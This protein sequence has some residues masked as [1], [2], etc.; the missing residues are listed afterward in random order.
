MGVDG[1]GLFSDDTA[2]DVRDA[3]REALEDGATDAAAEASVL[4]AFSDS[5]ADDDEGVVVWLAL[6]YS[7]SKLGRL[8]DMTRQRALAVL[9]AGADLA[10]WS[11]TGPRGV[12][13]R[14]AALEKVRAQLTGP[15]PKRRKVR[16]PARAVTGLPVGQV[17]G[18][19]ARSGRLYLMRV[20][21]LFDTRD[22]LYPVL[23]FLDYAEPDTPASAELDDIDDLAIGAWLIPPV[24]L[25]IMDR[26]QGHGLAVIGSLTIAR[27]GQQLANW[28]ACDWSDLTQHLDQRDRD[29]YGAQH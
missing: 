9:D 6:A 25:V 5:L 13:Q 1:P 7:Q 17:L 10:R 29:R 3:Y 4:A 23:R 22:G 12:E 27:E 15:Q 16:R 2:L 8:S 28:T 24:E 26:N 19:R 20:A 21:D 11:E 14:A 18:H